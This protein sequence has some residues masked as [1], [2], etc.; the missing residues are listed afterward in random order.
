MITGKTKTGFAFSLP[1]STL[2]NMELLDAVAETD[3]GN[4]LAVSRLCLQLLG[5]AQRKQL[6]DHLRDEKGRVPAQAVS[7]ELVEILE[8]FGKEGKN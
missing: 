8:A 5:K 7:R 6:Y 3:E 1:E 2:D 4:P